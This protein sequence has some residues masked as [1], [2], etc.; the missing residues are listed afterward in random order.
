[1]GTTVRRIRRFVPKLAEKASMNADEATLA[2]DCILG[3]SKTGSWKVSDIARTLPGTTSL[4]EMVR[5]FYDGLSDPRSNLDGLRDAW[6]DAVSKVTN[7]MPFIA[8]DPSDII[9][10]HGKKFDYLD[11]VSDRSDR[12]ER[13]GPGYPTIPIEAVDYEHWNLPLWHEVFRVRNWYSIQR[14]TFFSM[15]AY[16]IQREGGLVAFCI[17]NYHRACF[18]LPNV[19]AALPVLETPISSPFFF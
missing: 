2:A 10:L 12:D 13:K 15:L 6:L 19:D 8:V 11:V 5:S 14:L 17:T 9:K 1:M 7:N 18:L 16:G 3:I 4:R